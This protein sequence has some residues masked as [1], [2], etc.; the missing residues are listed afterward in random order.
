MQAIIDKYRKDGIVVPTSFNEV[1][2]NSKNFINGTGAVDLYGWDNYPAGG[3]DTHAKFSHI[4]ISMT[5]LFQ[6]LTAAT[7]TSGA[8]VR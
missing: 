3:S 2:N 8:P 1:N 4:H 6:D 7:R 5:S